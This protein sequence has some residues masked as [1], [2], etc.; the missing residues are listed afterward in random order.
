MP[1]LED[2]DFGSKIMANFNGKPGSGKT[3][4]A[5]SFPDPIYVF[6]CDGRMKPVKKYFKDRGVEKN[7]NFDTYTGQDFIRFRD[8]LV[9]LQDYCPYKTVICDS[10]TSIGT[11]IL[12]YMISVRGKATKNKGVIALSDIED[13]G[14]EARALEQVIDIGRVIPANFILT[15]HILETETYDLKTQR[16][17]INRKILTGGK[18]IAAVIP[19]LFD[20]CWH[21]Y[22]EG[23]ESLKYFVK[24]TGEDTFP[25]KTALPLDANIEWTDVMLYD[26]VK[27]S[28]EEYG[29]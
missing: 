15:A 28:I 13:F 26:I 7:I 3:I 22:K 11:M 17:I 16:T 20:E 8:K 27:G 2:I 18:K 23:G 21:F 1:T 14:G 29:K 5:C 25:V 24:T 10:V 6:D 4:A 9:G 12:N 19:A